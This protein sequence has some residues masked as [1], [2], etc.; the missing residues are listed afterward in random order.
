MPYYLF[1]L[2]LSF[3]IGIFAAEAKKEESPKTEKKQQAQKPKK[4]DDDLIITSKH[5]NYDHVNRQ[6]IFTRDVKAVNGDTT[7]TS[8]KMICYFDEK[9]DPYLVIAEGN[10]KITRGDQLG[11]SQKAVYKL[12]EETIILRQE[13]Q[14]FDGNNTI[15]A[16][17]ITFYEAKNI[18]IFDDPDCRFMREVVDE[19]KKETEKKKEEKDKKPETK[20]KAEEKDKKNTKEQKPK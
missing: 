10:V 2:L 8:D 12:K 17:I 3:N 18:S 6:A 19:K 14:L 7:M 15:K 4:A 5:L 9:N 20:D 1:A 16:R 13:P 11:T